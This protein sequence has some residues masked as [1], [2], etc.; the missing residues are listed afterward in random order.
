MVNGDDGG[1]ARRR[2]LNRD[3]ESERPSNGA[4]VR[5]SR[6]VLP[7]HRTGSG[8]NKR[9]CAATIRLPTVAPAEEEHVIQREGRECPATAIWPTTGAGRRAVVTLVERWKVRCYQTRLVTAAARCRL[10]AR[11]ARL[12]A[13]QRR[14]AVSCACVTRVARYASFVHDARAA[15]RAA[16]C[17]RACAVCV[18]N[19]HER[20]KQQR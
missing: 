20:L 1:G 10:M 14:R 16:P 7:V 4:T 12:R 19:A 8:N 18:L 17:A 15:R 9:R 2:A 6:H 3:A 13:Q 11:R 5:R